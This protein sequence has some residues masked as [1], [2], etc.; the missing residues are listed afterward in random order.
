L[1][2]HN[3]KYL[4]TRANPNGD[5][6]G[7][8]SGYLLVMRP[9]EETNEIRSR[10]MDQTLT[11]RAEAFYECYPDV[12]YFIVGVQSSKPLA[13]DA[14]SESLSKQKSIIEKLKEHGYKEEEIAVL[15]QRIT[16]ES[17]ELVALGR[18][19]GFKVTVRLS[20]RTKDFP[21]ENPEAVM[22]HFAS[23]ADA[24]ARCGA[25]SWGTSEFMAFG[26]G[27]SC[28]VFSFEDFDSIEVSLVERAISN[29]KEE[30]EK[31]A[32]SI[33]KQIG[34][35][36][37]VGAVYSD[38]GIKGAR[39]RPGMEKAERLVAG[40]VLDT[41]KGPILAGYW[42]AVCKLNIAATFSWA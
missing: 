7:K 33:G 13:E 37:A 32:R 9:D 30:A 1:S 39:L 12:S 20:A 34:E 15:D 26:V 29:A 35:L 5:R 6:N 36:V 10:E 24:I 28:V 2:P 41:V 16:G 18:G 3:A 42:Q 14:L 22:R 4:T 25:D 19:A 27:T 40:G 8:V 17:G 11:I 31:I 38:S 21:R 23:L